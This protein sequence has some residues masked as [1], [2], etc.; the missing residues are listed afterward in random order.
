MKSLLIACMALLTVAM[1]EFRSGGTVLIYRGTAKEINTAENNVHPS[2]WKV[3]LIVDQDTGALARIRYTT[4]SGAKTHRTLVV[5]NSHIVQ[6]TGVDGKAYSAITRIPTDCEIQES[7]GSETVYVKGQNTTLTVTAT[8]T[9]S[10]PRLL[11]RPGVGL[12]HLSE[13]GA[14]VLDE[15]NFV[16]SFDKTQTLMSNAADETIEATFGRLLNYVRSLGY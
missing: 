4:L 14:A 16:L 8:S 7:P 9:T 15:T 1:S 2:I 6:V 5:T 10:F 11:T 13:S 12:S 3:F